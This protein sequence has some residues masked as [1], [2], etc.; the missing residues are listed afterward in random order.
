M[1]IIVILFNAF[2]YCLFEDIYCKNT[3]RLVL[4][5]AFLNLTTYIP[6]NGNVAYL[7]SGC[8][9]MHASRAN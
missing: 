6:T 5:S 3:E 9:N 7:T 2:R 8:P 1:M 4:L